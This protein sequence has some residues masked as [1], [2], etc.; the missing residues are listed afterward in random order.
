MKMIEKKNPLK[1]SQNT[2]RVLVLHT[3][4]C[5]ILCANYR[6]EACKGLRSLVEHPTVRG[7]DI[8]LKEKC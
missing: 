5:C 3:F 1:S 7:T 6:D 2:S 4:Y 8:Y